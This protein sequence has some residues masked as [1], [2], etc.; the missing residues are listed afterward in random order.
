MNKRLRIAFKYRSESIVVLIIVIAIV[1]LLASNF[2]NKSD[3]MITVRSGPYV[4]MFLTEKGRVYS[5]ASPDA[6]SYFLF[7]KAGTL[8]EICFPSPIIDIGLSDTCAYALSNKG[9]LWMWGSNKNGQLCEPDLDYITSEPKRL[10]SEWNVKQVSISD[11]ICFVETEDGMLYAWGNN[12]IGAIGVTENIPT[13]I[14]TTPMEMELYLDLNEKVETIAA[15][16]VNISTLSNA[17]N[18]YRAGQVVPF[19]ANNEFYSAIYTRLMKDTY[20]FPAKLMKHCLGTFFD[21]YILADGSVF[22]NGYNTEGELCTKN[23][24]YIAQP[25]RLDIPFKIKDASVYDNGAFLLSGENDIY[26][27][28]CIGNQLN[29]SVELLPTSQK[30]KALSI[31]S[32]HGILLE[33]NGQPWI[34]QFATDI[35][36][37][38]IIYKLNLECPVLNIENKEKTPTFVKED[39]KKIVCGSN[40]I[41]SIM[42]DGKLFSWGLNNSTWAAGTGETT[43]AYEPT[44]IPLTAIIEDVY[45]G[46]GYCVAISDTG[47]VYTWGV[48]AGGNG[49]TKE[50]MVPKQLSLPE[51]IVKIYPGVSSCIA[52]GVSGSLYQWGNPSSTVSLGLTDKDMLTPLKVENTWG[53]TDFSLNHMQALALDGTG[54]VWHWG[55]DHT[56]VETRQNSIPTIIKMPEKIVSICAGNTYCYAIGES[57]K[58]Y[59]WGRNNWNNLLMGDDSFIIEHPTVLLEEYTFKEIKS[60][61]LSTLAVTQED[62]LLNWGLKIGGEE[63]EVC[64]LPEHI[65]GNKG[66]EAFSCSADLGVVNYKDGSALILNNKYCNPFKED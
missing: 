28:G 40:N 13:K 23:T 8:N 31:S 58:L 46:E 60:S 53:F 41:I 57:G 59:G 36:K 56:V 10:L 64:T 19:Q 9:E 17:N 11:Y 43:V 25:N 33:T 52:K 20:S 12:S 39:V 54:N 62:A 66:I 44:Y 6:A 35:N 24:E 32:T 48:Y 50:L 26:Y 15:G 49:T 37:E 18:L 55:T 34:I 3:E 4:S 5:V 65:S 47:A 61:Y 21:L 45:I 1:L 38:P 63:L 30:W 51:R 29:Q 16:N 14:I 27:M 22:V 42:E 7:D 2:F